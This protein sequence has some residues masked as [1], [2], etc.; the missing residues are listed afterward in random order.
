VIEAWEA[1]LGDAR[2]D[3]ADAA[4][5]WRVGLPRLGGQQ[6]ASWRVGGRIDPEFDDDY[7][8]IQMLHW[9]NSDEI[10]TLR[11][12]MIWTERTPEGVAG[13]LRHELEHTIQIAAAVELD[14]LHQRACEELKNRSATGKSYNSI[15]MEMDANRAAARFLRGRYDTDRLRQL[16]IADDE[17]AACFRPTADPEP[18][19]TLVDRMRAFIVSVMQ[20]KDFV[21]QLEMAPP[22][23]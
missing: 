5:I 2:V 18:L 15:P 13:L 10:R 6:A 20:D 1:A 3:T 12:V 9:A 7:E 14:Q 23:Q 8:F 4:L 19:D 21:H 22:P 11:R 16:I 17:D